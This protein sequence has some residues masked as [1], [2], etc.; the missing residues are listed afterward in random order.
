MAADRHQRKLSLAFEK[1]I[2]KGKEVIKIRDLETAFRG[3]DFEMLGQVTDNMMEVINTEFMSSVS[4]VILD[5]LVDSGELAGKSAKQKG[6][7]RTAQLVLDFDKTNPKASSWAKNESAMLVTNVSAGTKQAIR[8]IMYQAF[9]EGM[10]P[11]VAARLIRA[12]V[13]LTAR[14]A[15]A[16]RKVREELTSAKGGELVK[17]GK[18]KVR[19]PEGGLPTTRV[20]E[21][22][23]RYSA[24]SLNYRARMI[25][26]TETMAASNEGQRQLWEQATGQGL[27]AGTELREWIIT[28]DDRLCVICEG[29]AG[30]TVGINE[31]FELPSGN[32]MN[33]PA[34]PQCRCAQG[35]TTK[36]SKAVKK[37]EAPTQIGDKSI[38]L[39]P[40]IPIAAPKV[41]TTFDGMADAHVKG[42]D[43]ANQAMV[44]TGKLTQTQLDEILASEE[45]KGAKKRWKAYYKKHNQTPNPEYLKVMESAIDENQTNVAWQKTIQKW[46]DDHIVMFQHVEGD[47]G[48]FGVTVSAQRLGGT[49]M[50][51]ESRFTFETGWAVRK[52][53]PVPGVFNVGEGNMATILRHEYGHT[54]G[55]ALT[56]T[57]HYEQFKNL[58]SKLGDKGVKN[59]VSDYATTNMAETFSEVFALAT[60]TQ[61][62]PKNFT[63]EL[64]NLVEWMQ[65]I[66][67]GIGGQI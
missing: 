39:Y 2:I 48:S 15:M 42:I 38:T 43:V 67:Y 14:Q 65:E 57:K 8:E 7:Y 13:G 12:E 56:G 24:R 29:V 19:V 3:R 61:Y 31:P 26:R 66:A 20:I 40:P 36:T 59:Q 17:M 27:L 41:P 18:M 49:S 4:K 37:V 5:T 64:N 34:H 63:E 9:E 44:K 11:R 47:I 33:P 32:V 10:P 22:T 6:D 60:D 62:N 21:L 30:Q 55:S 23:E 46:G 52:K 16:V 51:M 50:V 58:V 35:L 53:I 28:P 25:A 45:L 1:A 54:V